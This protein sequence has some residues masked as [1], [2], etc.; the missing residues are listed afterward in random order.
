MKTKIIIAILSVVVGNLMYPQRIEAQF[1]AVKANALAALTGT[2][3]LGVD[4][5]VADKWTVDLSGYWNP[6]N[7]PSI[8]SRFYG[9]Q[10]GTKHWLYESFVG[11]FFGVQL[12]YGN[13]LWGNSSRYFRGNLTGVGFSYG[14]SWM[15]S[16]RW[17]VTVEAGLG[18]FYMND[19]RRERVDP[20]YEPIYIRRYKRLAVG[21]S[22]AEVS[23]SY[24]F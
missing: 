14:Y 23:F 8:S 13:Y 3:N 9:V 10:A 12:T 7:S 6:I 17:N 20:A 1:C 4:V 21:P 5:S 19:T 22:R 15:L 16:K 18:L 2:V 24:L 11:H